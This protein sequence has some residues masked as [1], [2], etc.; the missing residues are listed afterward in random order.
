MIDQTVMSLEEIKETINLP[1]LSDATRIRCVELAYSIG[2][3]HGAEQAAEQL[4]G[5]RS[6]LKALPS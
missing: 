6:E 4:M 1:Y 2:R 5:I 3:L